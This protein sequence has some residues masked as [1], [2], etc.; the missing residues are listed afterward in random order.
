MYPI[1]TSIY[2]YYINIVD[3]N[4]N[5]QQFNGAVKISIVNKAVFWYYTCMS[6]ILF[7]KYIP[8][9]NPQAI[10]HWQKEL[11]TKLGLKGRIILATEGI[12]ATLGGAQPMVQE[13]IQ[14]M[15]A[16]E[17]FADIDFKESSGNAD[18]FPRLRIVVKKEIVRLDLDTDHYTAQTG[19]QL[20]EP[21]EAHELIKN[22]KNLLLL[23]GRN[24]YESNIGTFTGA[25]RPPI[26]NFRELPGYIDQNV[27][28]F[29]D[30]E[31]LMFCTGGIRCERASSYLQSKGVAKKVYQIKGG[32]HRYIEQFPDGYFRGKNYVFDARVAVPANDDIIG[33]C[34]ICTTKADDII[35]CINSFCNKQFIGC[36]PCV[37]QLGNTCSQACNTLVMTN[38]VPIRTKF[39]K[40]AYHANDY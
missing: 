19:G 40:M 38:A 24:K 35:N 21:H 39:K 20:L 3:A 9:Q 33:S 13:Y 6:I 37:D 27:D 7:Y 25:M 8:I 1:F 2:I 36:A 14:A 22:N 29:K 28:Q 4:N 17:L 34:D 11:C 5:L 18:Y 15:N 12:N 10:M 31:V 32:I 26:E 30:K 23:D 16:H